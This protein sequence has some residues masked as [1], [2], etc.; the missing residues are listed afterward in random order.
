MFVDKEDEYL[1]EQDAA[2]FLE[3]PVRLLRF[4]R[5]SEQQYGPKWIRIG[6]AIRY[7]KRSVRFCFDHK[8]DIFVQ[9]RGIGAEDDIPFTGSYKDDAIE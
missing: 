3:V 9:K 4:W 5:S 6:R 7:V 8:G 1:T 2:D